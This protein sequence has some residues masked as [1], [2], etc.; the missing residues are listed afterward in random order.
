MRKA[1]SGSIYVVVESESAEQGGE[2][3]WACVTAYI[4]AGHMFW[5]NMHNDFCVSS[6]R[7]NA[8]LFYFSSDERGRYTSLGPWE[9]S[10]G[11]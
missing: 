7:Y 8:F 5:C 2:A 3:G 10:S 9:A 1:C 6:Y 4:A 11:K